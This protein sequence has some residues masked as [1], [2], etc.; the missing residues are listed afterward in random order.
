VRASTAKAT[1]NAAVTYNVPSYRIGVASIGAS[2]P[3]GNVHASASTGTLT[4]V[5]SVRGLCRWPL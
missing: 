5:I 3:T 4:R 1:F 2:S